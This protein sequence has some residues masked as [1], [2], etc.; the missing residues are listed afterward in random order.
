MANYHVIYDGNCNLCVTFSQLLEKFDRGKLF[1]YIP[2]QDRETLEQFDIK[3]EDCQMGMILIDANNPELRWQGS[4]AAE[5]IARLLPAGELFIAAYRAIPGMKWVGDRAYAQ[6]RD[7]RYN[8]FGKRNSTYHSAYPIGCAAA[9]N[10]QQRSN[11]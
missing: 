11:Y 4:D 10:C 8:W 2:M 9:N 3:E 5:E 1:D 6:I 7:N